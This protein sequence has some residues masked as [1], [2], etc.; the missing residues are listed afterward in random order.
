MRVAVN[1]NGIVEVSFCHHRGTP[2]RWQHI[3]ASGFSKYVRS[4]DTIRAEE[5][6]IP[7]EELGNVIGLLYWA[8]PVV[9][10]VACRVQRRR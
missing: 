2:R 6:G 7:R 9:N 4:F 10:R 5:L 8:A 1:E 3:P